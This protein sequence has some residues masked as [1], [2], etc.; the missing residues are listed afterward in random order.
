[1]SPWQSGGVPRSSSRSASRT[2]ALRAPWA[3]ASSVGVAVAPGVTRSWGR[4]AARLGCTTASFTYSAATMGGATTMR[5]AWWTCVR[6]RG[7]RVESSRTALTAARPGRF[8]DVAVLGDAGD[9]RGPACAAERAHGDAGGSKGWVAA[10][11]SPRAPAPPTA[12]PRSVRHRR[13][14]R[15]QRP[16]FR[17]RLHARPRWERVVVGT[18]PNLTDS[19]PRRIAPL[20][21]ARLPGPSPRTVQ[22]AHGHLFSRTRGPSRRARRRRPALPVGAARAP[23]PCGSRP[24]NPLR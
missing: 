6:G 15:P 4:P 17:R 16:R 13:L 5:S 24:R 8:R 11:D 9:R 10:L 3:A 12:P 22:Y 18:R 2:S 19:P 21:A 23:H 20:G 14:D 1:M 7:P